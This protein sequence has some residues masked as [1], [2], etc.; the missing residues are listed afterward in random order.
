MPIFDRWELAAAPPDA[1]LPV[2]HAAMRAILLRRG[3]DSAEALRRFVAPT[4]D[5]LHDPST[6]H[7][8]DH[9][10]DRISRAIREKET[11][12]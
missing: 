8:I 1:P 7:G 9:A 12:L 10:C 4:I 5:D 6:I 2:V 11:I 3:I